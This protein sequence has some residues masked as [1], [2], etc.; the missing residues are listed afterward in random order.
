VRRWTGPGPTVGPFEATVRR[1]LI[2]LGYDPAH[3]ETASIE[4]VSK[5]VRAPGAAATALIL[6]LDLPRVP[7]GRDDVVR[8]IGCHRPIKDGESWAVRGGTDPVHIDC[9]AFLPPTLDLA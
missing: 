4:A 5:H 3:V 1:R 8:C 6:A 2:R 7:P 9:V